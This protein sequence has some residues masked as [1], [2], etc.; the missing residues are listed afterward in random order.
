MKNIHIFL[1]F[2]FN[3]I[4]SLNAQ[5]TLSGNYENLTILKGKHIINS[6]VIVG[7]S[8]KVENGAKVEFVDNGTL[9]CGGLIEML[10]NKYD[11]EFYGK[12]NSE[13]VGLIINNNNEKSI[14]IT[15]VIFRNLQ[16]PLYFDFGWKRNL[17]SITHNKFDNNI[18]KV[19]LIQVLNTP[20]GIN[21]SAYVQFEL[22]NNTFS[23]NS[24]SLYFED[25]KNDQI[26]FNITQNVFINNFV[27]GSKTYN[28]A[29][30]ILYGRVDQIYKKF[31]PTIE[32]NS[33]VNNNLVDILTDTIVHLANIGLYGTEKMIIFKNNYFGDNNKYKIY[34]GIYDQDKNYALPKIILEP[35]LN[36]PLNNIDAHVYKIFNGKNGIEI[37]EKAQPINIFSSF[38]FRSNKELDYS[39]SI[40]KYINLKNDTS[41]IET[42]KRINYNITVIDKNNVK[43]D[44]LEFANYSKSGGYFKIE[45]IQDLEYNPISEIKIGYKN[46]LVKFYFQKLLID[47]INNLKGLENINKIKIANAPKFK[48]FIEFSIGTGGS[49]FT[50]TVSSPSLFTNEVTF[51]NTILGSYHFSKY[52]STSIGFSYFTLGNIDYN[53][54]NL[55][56]ISRGFHF[57]TK[58]LTISPVLH[59]KISESNLNSK[60]IIYTSYLGLGLD[61]IKFNPTSSYKGL[62]YDLQP[63]GTGGQF[64]DNTKSPYNLSTYGL[65]FS[66]RFDLNFNKKYSTGI[67]FSY[68]RTFSNYIDDVGNDLYPNPN[69]LFQTLKENSAAAVYFSNPTSQFI[70][71]GTLR[72]SPGNPNDSYF[73]FNILFTRKLFN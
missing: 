52:L 9:I 39:N 51:N 49:M 26:H 71:Q 21:D 24:A 6:M 4:S 34:E 59:L 42:E 19:S 67:L 68:H 47:S 11:I 69:L 55:E 60:K 33:F 30:N 70:P 72:S 16:M 64:I 27:Y 1:L 63:L 10:G 37:N 73:S 54:T 61:F 48:K 15:N 23:N 43:I 38:L 40:I 41:L 58:M 2:I 36:L 45:N 56:E 7:K 57:S 18:G 5:D 25:L 62:I 31:L 3:S 20:Y 12:K 22:S 46:Y 28:I 13:G 35:F 53:S 17:V 32:R 44:L 14:I 50:G 8:L 66:Y 65:L 29:N